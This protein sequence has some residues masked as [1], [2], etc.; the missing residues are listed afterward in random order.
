MPLE[1]ELEEF[2][3]ACQERGFALHMSQMVTAKT[4]QREQPLHIA[5]MESTS[6]YSPV[7]PTILQELRELR[8]A[9]Q[10]YEVRSQAQIQALEAKSQTKIQALEAIVKPRTSR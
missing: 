4:A 8:Q 2:T 9:L 3:A 1:K 6:A 10:A 5:V 7:M